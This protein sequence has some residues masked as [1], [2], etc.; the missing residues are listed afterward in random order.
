MQGTA[1]KDST[2]HLDHHPGIRH[3][4]NSDI[5]L[6]VSLDNDAIAVP[7]AAAVAVPEVTRQNILD[8]VQ[9]NI[10]NRATVMHHHDVDPIIMVETTSIDGI[11]L[12]AVVTAASH[13]G[14]GCSNTWRRNIWQSY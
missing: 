7:A 12:I 5:T 3:D 14:S 6:L 2:V 11:R 9:K 8:I 1:K 13:H 4:D 10:I